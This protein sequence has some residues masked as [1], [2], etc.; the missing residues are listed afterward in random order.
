MAKV[1][2]VTGSSRGIGRATVRVAAQRGWDV[3]INYLASK[4]DAQRLAEEVESLGRRALLV[5]GDMGR[6]EDIK[7]MFETVDAAFGPP[8]AVVCNAGITGKAGR[9]EALEIDMLRRVVDVNL[10]GSIVTAREAVRRMS[11]KRGGRGGS[12]V[13]LSSVA[14]FIG[15]AGEWLPY[16]ATK[17]AIN[18]FT[19][20]LAREV[21]GEGIRVNAVSPGIIDTEIHSSAG[22]GDRVARLVPTLPM[23]RIGTAEEVAEAILFFMSGEAAYSIGAVLPITGGR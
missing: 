17:G 7:G 1:V 9:L 16:A 5:R 2:L 3:C 19:L 10:V 11:T 20:G 18:T 14:S 23:P 12:I 4:D 21:A 8:D 6:E 15:G 13:L 22:A